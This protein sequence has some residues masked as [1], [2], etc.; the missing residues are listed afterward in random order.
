SSSSSATP[1]RRA[2]ATPTSRA[3]R[4]WAGAG[5][6]DSRTVGMASGQLAR[7]WARRGGRRLDRVVQREHPVESRDPEDLQQSLVPA[8]E[9]EA[10]TGRTQAL[11]RTNEHAEPRR[12]EELHRTQVDHHAAGTSLHQLDEAFPQPRRG[13]HVDLAADLQ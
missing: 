9:G 5:E 8:D 13:V 10:A 6:N 12:V 2:T 11:E 7:V 3:V 1:A 4:T